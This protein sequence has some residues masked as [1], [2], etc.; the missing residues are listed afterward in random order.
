MIDCI[1]DPDAFCWA[2]LWDWSEK[3]RN[4]L[5]LMF[6]VKEVLVEFV[7]F[8]YLGIKGE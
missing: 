3:F 7:R 2:W 5:V 6:P 4:G 1:G 8:Q